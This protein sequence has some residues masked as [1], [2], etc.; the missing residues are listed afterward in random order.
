MHTG[1]DPA[2]DRRPPGVPQS[3]GKQPIPPELL[4]TL[5]AE[6]EAENWATPSCSSRLPGLALS[7]GGAFALPKSRLQQLF[8]AALIHDALS[9]ADLGPVNHSQPTA[10]DERAIRRHTD[11]GARAA[12][13]LPLL[14]D[15]KEILRHHHERYDGRGCDHLRGEEIPLEARILLLAEDFEKLVTPGPYP[16][17][18]PR[19]GA[20]ERL[21]GTNGRHLDQ[22]II[23][24][25]RSEVGRRIFDDFL[26][27]TGDSRSPRLRAF[28]ET[29]TNRLREHLL[30]LQAALS[31]R[32][33]APAWLHGSR[34]KMAAVLVA[35]V[36]VLTIGTGLVSA[37]QNAVPGDALYPAKRAIEDIQLLLTPHGAELELHLAFARER[38]RETDTLIS[39]G[40]SVP[41]SLLADLAHE[42]QVL[43]TY[44]GDLKGERTYKLAIE[45]RDHGR[46]ARSVLES[47]ELVDQESRVVLDNTLKTVAVGEYLGA[48]TAAQY[49][50]DK[51]G[52]PQGPRTPGPPADRTPGRSGDAPG[53]N[54]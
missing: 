3:V 15:C 31:S 4:E 18:R 9:A 44:L 1:P 12:A 51:K 53:R 25:L 24:F 37:S 30:H 35:V 27:R 36:G 19:E 32:R 26:R 14:E 33:T 41:D 46:Q 38:L 11:E 23:H 47:L 28:A 10:Q 50:G 13:I 34:A 48:V 40:H 54:R 22:Q 6:T 52:Q 8:Y 43:T 21:A 16:E 2:T 29:A 5:I 39:K 49:D 7:I 45:L 42:T 17:V 20:V